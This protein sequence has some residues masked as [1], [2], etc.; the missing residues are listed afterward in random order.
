MLRV[1]FYVD[2]TASFILTKRVSDKQLLP[3]LYSPCQNFVCGYIV[4]SLGNLITAQLAA[5]KSQ[6]KKI[7]DDEQV[8]SQNNQT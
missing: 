2:K 7:G 8:D 4:A 6:Y 5:E 1:A 3:F